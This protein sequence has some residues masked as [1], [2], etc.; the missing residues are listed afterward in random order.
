ML[1]VGGLRPFPEPEWLPAPDYSSWVWVAMVLACG[2][3]MAALI[4]WARRRKRLEL[5]PA[6]QLLQ[7]L[8]LLRSECERAK[9]NGTATPQYTDL[10]RLESSQAAV[11]DTVLD[12]AYIS[13]RSWW[14][15]Y[16]VES[17][18]RKVGRQ[19]GLAAKD[20]QSVRKL[21]AILVELEHARYSGRPVGGRWL[22]LQLEWAAAVVAE[23]ACPTKHAM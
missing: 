2:V 20:Y 18:N 10:A 14:E 23:L 17:G 8:M 19:V 5:E 22:A 13:L 3:G 4:V 7:T 11:A 15:R 21:E 6:L 16:A 1:G 12:R 9:S